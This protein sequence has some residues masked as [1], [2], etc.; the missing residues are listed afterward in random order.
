MEEKNKLKSEKIWQMTYFSLIYVILDCL[1]LFSLYLCMP[2]LDLFY[3]VACLELFPL[4]LCNTIS[5]LFFQAVCL[6][7]NNSR[8]ATW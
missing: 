4:Y 6:E 5:G 7:G 3:Q 1:E 8:Q 2:I